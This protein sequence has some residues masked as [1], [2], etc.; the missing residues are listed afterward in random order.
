M[1][2]NRGVTEACIT[3]TAEITENLLILALI[4]LKAGLDYR[5]QE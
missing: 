3:I 1:W 4:F 5:L 2:I